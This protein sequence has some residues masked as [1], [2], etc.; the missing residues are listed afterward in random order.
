MLQ[1]KNA[2][3]VIFFLRD[4]DF[5]DK[6]QQ[7][8]SAHILS[9]TI[10]GEAKAEDLNTKEAIASVAMNRFKRLNKNKKIVTLD[11]VCL[12][13]EIFTCWRDDNLEK[14]DLLQ[15]NMLDPNY[16]ICNRIA[17]KAAKGFLKDNTYNSVRY[18]RKYECPK[19]SLSKIP[20]IEIGNFVFYDEF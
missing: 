13:S 19:W 6:N 3:S 14:K 7:E 15:L 18:H 12:D 11:Q 17:R 5:K 20:I 2:K 10:L 1:N 8:R 16:R 4:N 9:R